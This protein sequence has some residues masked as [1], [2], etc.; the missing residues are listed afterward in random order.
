MDAI[1]ITDQPPFVN[2]GVGDYSYNLMNCLKNDNFIIETFCKKS[3]NSVPASYSFNIT[4][5]GVIGLISLFKEIR[6]KKPKWILFQYVP[7]AYSK[8]GIPI[9]IPFFLLIIRISGIKVHTNFH[10]VSIRLWNG[11][12]SGIVRSICQ[13]FIAY[14]ISLFANS[15]QTSNKYYAS[16]LFPFKIKILPIPSNF[17]TFCKPTHFSN[18]FYPQKK[19]QIIISNANRCNDYFFEIIYKLFSLNPI[20]KLIIIGRV[21]PVEIL[22]IESQLKKLKLAD[23]TEIYVN[24]SSDKY[25]ELF[26]LADIYFQLEVVNKNGKGGISAK[27]G[28]IA[29]ALMLGIP[30]ITTQGDLTDTKLFEDR[31]TVLF[32]PAHNPQ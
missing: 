13:R 11:K 32:I 6:K 10:E 3:N 30:T 12:V 8:I 17:E 2:D 15:V 22:F 14:L 1:I 7:Y 31:K 18:T 23:R 19:E 21:T 20:Y 29:T 16:L 4:S 28:A 26:A 5:W 27:S 24:I 9:L 25:V